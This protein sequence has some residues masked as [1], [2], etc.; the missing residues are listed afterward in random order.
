ME[1]PVNMAVLTTGVTEAAEELGSAVEAAGLVRVT[2]RA[3]AC[4]WLDCAA[5]DAPGNRVSYR[6]QILHSESPFTARE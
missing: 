4:R 1:R 6:F 2:I 5:D 3:L